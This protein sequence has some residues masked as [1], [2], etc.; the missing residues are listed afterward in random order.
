MPPTP[1]KEKR[2]SQLP[3]V[4]V[5]GSRADWIAAAGADRLPVIHDTWYGKAGAYHDPMTDADQEGKYYKAFVTLLGQTDRV[6]MQRDKTPG[7]QERDGYIAVFKFQDLELH[8]DGAVTLK[9]TERVADIR[10]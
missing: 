8:E 2:L 10:K 6:I 9:V 3:R 4:T 5:K 7:S 1:D